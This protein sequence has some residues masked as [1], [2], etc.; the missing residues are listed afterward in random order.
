MKKLSDANANLAASIDSVAPSERIITALANA[1]EADAV[2]RDGSRGPD[3]K[4]RVQ[5]ASLLLAYRVGR[6]VERQQVITANS[7][8]PKESFSEK[9]ARSPALRELYR[10]ELERAEEAAKAGP[11]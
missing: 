3:H 8:E 11:S 1:L 7:N 10:Q 9:L 6:P 4:T 5:A 2:N